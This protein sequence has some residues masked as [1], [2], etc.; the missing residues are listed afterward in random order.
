[1][2]TGLLSL[3]CL[4]ALVP[5]AVS[6]DEL[7]QN[8]TFENDTTGWTS[9]YSGGTWTVDAGQYDLDPDMEGYAYKYDA[10]FGRMYQT[11]DVANPGVRF[12][13]QAQLVAVE[14]NPAATYWAF[15]ALELQY[16]DAAGNYLGRTLIGYATPHSSLSSSTTQH[17]ITAVD[18][19]WHSYQFNIQDE[20]VNLTGVSPSE[21]RKVKVAMLDTTNGC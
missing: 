13:A 2:K 11:L 18:S 9:E 8:G 5:L 6:A 1:M 20:L 12:S 16:L 10:T 15:A 3:I 19:L 17:I 14:L 21:V 7:I 4:V